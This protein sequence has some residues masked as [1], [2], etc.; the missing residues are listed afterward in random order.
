MF[1]IDPKIVELK[2]YNRVPHLLTPVITEPR[3]AFQ[4]LQYCIAEMERRYTLLDALA[5]RDIRAYNRKARRER[6]SRLPYIVNFDLAAAMY[7]KAW[8]CIERDSNLRDEPSWRSLIGRIKEI[9]NMA[10]SRQ[11]PG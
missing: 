10:I 1:L 2:S 3:K 4:A 7:E 5:V 6:V 9:Q 8:Q 11:P